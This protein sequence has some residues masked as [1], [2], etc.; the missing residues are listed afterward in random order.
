MTT[1]DDYQK[2]AV[3]CAARAVTTPSEQ[4]RL[5]WLGMEKYWRKR[6]EEVDAPLVPDQSPMGHDD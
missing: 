5:Y 4:A 2:K 1:K 6:A 3:D